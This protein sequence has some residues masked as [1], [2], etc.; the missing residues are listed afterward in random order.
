MGAAD[1][2]AGCID[3]L[4]DDLGCDL[5]LMIRLVFS[6]DPECARVVVKNRLSREWLLAEWIGGEPF[7]WS[8]DHDMAAAEAV[9]GWMDRRRSELTDELQIERDD[10]RRA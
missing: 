8:E 5:L 6:K 9:T 3:D 2:I 10:R 4:L 7:E 1:D